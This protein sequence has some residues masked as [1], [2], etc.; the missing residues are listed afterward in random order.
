MPLLIRTL[1][2]KGKTHEQPPNLG[3]HLKSIQK[4]PKPMH[5]EETL[6]QL[7][8]KYSL[9]LSKYLANGERIIYLLN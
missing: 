3:I 6:P 2:L 5:D 9:Y 7:L 1:K 8:L 4:L